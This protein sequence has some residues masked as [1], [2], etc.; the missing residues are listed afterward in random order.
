MRDIEL[1]QLREE[2]EK[3]LEMEFRRTEEDRRKIEQQKAEARAKGAIN[4][5]KDKGKE[6][7]DTEFTTPYSTP[8]RSN[9]NTNGGSSAIKSVPNSV[10]KVPKSPTQEEP[11][12]RLKVIGAFRT[13]TDGFIK[14]RTGL[15]RASQVMPKGD[16][17]PWVRIVKDIRD[18]FYS[19]QVLMKELAREYQTVYLMPTYEDKMEEDNVEKISTSVTGGLLS[20]RNRINSINKYKSKDPQDYTQDDI[21]LSNVQANLNLQLQDITDAFNKIQRSYVNQMER[22]ATQAKDTENS[23]PIR[24][25]EESAM[26][27]FT[28]I[29]D[30]FTE[31]QKWQADHME[32]DI[33]IYTKDIKQLHRSITQ[34]VEMFNDLHTQVIE[35][36]TLIDRIDYTI[37]NVQYTVKEAVVQTKKAEEE[38]KKTGQKMLLLLLLIAIFGL[39]IFIMIRIILG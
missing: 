7:V 32:K 14:R 21:I 31:S 36:G 35:Q 25:L 17:L 11:R 13:R 8:I 28:L 3:Q 33:D 15:S 5:K 10:S 4:M 1:Q 26:Q 39:I 37:K 29:D 30:G 38:Q 22:R 27:D 19:V 23:D 20:I 2:K 24:D 9:P 12:K 34:L 6:K 18:D 16:D